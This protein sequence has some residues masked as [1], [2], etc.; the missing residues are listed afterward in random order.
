MKIILVITGLGVGGAERQVIDLADEF[1]KGGHEVTLVCLTG[2]VI[3]RPESPSI[4]LVVLGMSKSPLRFFRA[5]IAFKKVIESFRP[6]IVHSH[7]VHA[8]LFT[9]VL[10]MWMKMP[11]L[12]SSAHNTSE[13]AWW[14]YMAYRVTDRLADIST[15]VS[16]EGVSVFE[17]KGAVGKNRMILVYNGISTTKFRFDSEAR[18]RVRA[19]LGLNV[20]Q[21]FLLAVGSLSS[22]KD[23]PNLLE[24]VAK[25]QLSMPNFIVAIAGGGPLALELKQLV[26]ELGLY[27]DRVLFLGIRKDVVDL[28]SAADVFVLSSAWEGFGLV[29]A[30]A[31]AMQR[32]VVATDCGGVREVLADCGF[33]VEPKDSDKLAEMLKSVMQIDTQVAAQIGLAARRRIETDFAVDAAA[34]GWLA[35]YGK[36]REKAQLISERKTNV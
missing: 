20:D 17:R 11:V 27:E 30:E 32:L 4:R 23:Y 7:L 16:A 19:S 22:Q 26:I 1:F 13:G 24:A 33:L 15:N 36:Y 18:Q 9:R 21:K 34:R 5:A 8:N 14:R 28:M 31:M 6:D 3:L 35:I 2:P 12:I 25:L 29:V 10:R